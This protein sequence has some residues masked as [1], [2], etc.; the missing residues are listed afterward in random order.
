VA[1]A[2][3]V[4]AVSETTARDA[5]AWLRVAPERVVVAPHGPGQELQPPTERTSE[6]F[7]YVGDDEP[8]KNVD[9]L[10]A[11]HARYRELGGAMPLMLAGSAAARADAIGVGDPDARALADLHSRA[12]ALVHA[13]RDEGFGLTVLEAMSVGTPV[14]AVRNAAIEE[15]AGDAALVVDPG[16]LAQAMQRL[17]RDQS[18]QQTLSAAGRHRAAAYSWQRSARAHIKAYTLARDSQ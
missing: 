7:L 6:H 13:S 11:A 8:R 5:I 14:I 3:A 12:I 2:G 18:L 1:H 15:L 9:G 10:L 4:V 16:E 17:E